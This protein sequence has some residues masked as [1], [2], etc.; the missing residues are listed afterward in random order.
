[1]CF[2]LYAATTA[3]RTQGPA[4]SRLWQEVSSAP[5]RPPYWQMTQR[6]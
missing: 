6:S 2:I 3:L 1:M 5:G 4:G